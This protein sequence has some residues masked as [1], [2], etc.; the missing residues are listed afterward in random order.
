MILRRN[1][2]VIVFES[3]YFTAINY[4]NGNLVTERT[5]VSFFRFFRRTS[6]VGYTQSQYNVVLRYAIFI[7]ESKN[8]IRSAQKCK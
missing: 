7:S 4:K 5:K 1:M 6:D 8:I 3:T 2:I